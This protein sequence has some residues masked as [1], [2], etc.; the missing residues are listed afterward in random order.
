MKVYYLPAYEYSSF[1]YIF[2]YLNI[3]AIQISNVKEIE[4]K[5]NNYLLM[6]TGVFSA[7]IGK[8][9][10][11]L[12][13]IKEIF[14]KPKF[15]IVIGGPHFNIMSATDFIKAFPDVSYICIGPGEKFLEKLFN[16]NIPPGIYDGLQFG[17]VRNYML[18]ESNLEK[19][20]DDHEIRISFDG[21]SCRWGRCLFCHHMVNSP[22]YSPEKI[23]ELINS[24]SDLGRYKFYFLDNYINLKKLIALLEMLSKTSYRD[25]LDLTIF[26]ARVSDDL[27]VL[28]EVISKFRE[29]PIKKI[30]F[31][32]E[33]YHQELLNMYKK[34]TTIEQI[35]RT[36]NWMISN[37]IYIGANLLF[38]MPGTKQ[39]HR[40]KYYD[41]VEK[42]GDSNIEI[43]T[44]FFRLS[45][46]IKMFD[47]LDKFKIK[48]TGESYNISDLTG[49]DELCRRPLVNI[50]KVPLTYLKFT[51]W[52]EE[53]QRWISRFDDLKRYKDFI[54]PDYNV[55]RETKK[56]VYKSR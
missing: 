10:E 44:S 8:M 6:S 54:S 18:T 27:S 20:D 26:G 5:E 31:G 39:E 3:E 49:I 29:N 19:L 51:H 43:R 38:G 13:D 45:S 42:Y 48:L 22:G 23:F 14:D 41:F 11:A 46:A 37:N 17:E 2:S 50:P 36:M 21:N 16:E 56:F 9:I 1:E 52:D 4:N 12:R 30:S 40:D 7:G 33:F 25:S 55:L 35:D 34:G 28:D 47:M 53:E 24:F 32:I 15:T